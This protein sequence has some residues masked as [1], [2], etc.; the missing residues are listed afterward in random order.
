MLKCGDLQDSD[1][2]TPDHRQNSNSAVTDMMNEVR[3]REV[4]EG[5]VEVTGN[6]GL[7]D[8][9]GNVL[10][11]QQEQSSDG[12]Q[13]E[14]LETMEADPFWCFETGHTC[15]SEEAEAEKKQEPAKTKKDEQERTEL[16]KLC[17]LKM[18]FMTKP[19]DGTEDTKV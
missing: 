17:C 13:K 11:A 9:W 3:D 12:N 19:E 18:G 15:N 10:G 6:G 2:T 1:E 16:E 8:N 4:E 7:E 5:E 14:D